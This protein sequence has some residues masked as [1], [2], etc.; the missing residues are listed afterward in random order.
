MVIGSVDGVG[1]LDMTPDAL[2]VGWRN[3]APQ[4]RAKTR[5]GRSA[6]RAAPGSR[7]FF[8]TLQLHKNFNQQ[9]SDP[10]FYRIKWLFDCIR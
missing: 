5:S 4:A 10:V 2:G 9:T 7:R 8:S 3:G 1:T 6:Y